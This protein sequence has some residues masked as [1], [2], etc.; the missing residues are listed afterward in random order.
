MLPPP[1]AGPESA[2]RAR[3][4]PQRGAGA[5]GQGLL[6]PHRPRQ[7]QPPGQQDLSDLPRCLP[8]GRLVNNN[9]NTLYTIRKQKKGKRNVKWNVKW[10]ESR[11][12]IFGVKWHVY[13]Y[14]YAHLLHIED[15]FIQINMQFFTKTACLSE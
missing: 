11:G 10:R 15:I 7:A 1:W 3:P 9:N 13:L 14:E 8:T 2:A 5:G 6:L 12:G 4:L